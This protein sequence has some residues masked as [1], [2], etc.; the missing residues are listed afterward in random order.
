MEALEFQLEEAK[1][2]TNKKANVR[3]SVALE[4][5][6]WVQK[7]YKKD[8]T[9]REAAAVINEE[10]KSKRLETYSEKHL[11]MIIRPLDFHPGKAGRRPKK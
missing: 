10:L 4:I 2:Q 9:R 3:K 5:A 8:L 7:N 6:K 1:L 11:I